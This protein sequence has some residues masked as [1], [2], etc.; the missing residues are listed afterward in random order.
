MI[1]TLAVMKT[2]TER[3]EDL[4]SRPAL[5]FTPKQ[6][7]MLSSAS[8]KSNQKKS[9]VT[10]S[11][12]LTIVCGE[13]S[14][15]HLQFTFPSPKSAKENGEKEEDENSIGSEGSREARQHP[16]E[17]T[18]ATSWWLFLCQK[19]ILPCLPS[20]QHSAEN[21]RHISE[22]LRE[23]DRAEEAVCEVD[24]Q[25]GQDEGA[26]L[27]HSLGKA[28]FHLFNQFWSPQL[29]KQTTIPSSHAGETGK[30][31]A[32]DANSFLSLLCGTRMFSLGG[33]DTVR[34][35]QLVENMR[36]EMNV[37]RGE[38]RAAVEGVDE[39]RGTAELF[40]EVRG[41][42][43]NESDVHN[44]INRKNDENNFSLNA[45]E[46]ELYAI[47][48]NILLDPLLFASSVFFK[49]QQL[50]L[51]ASENAIF[52]S[53]QRIACVP[54]IKK[55]LLEL[56]SLTFQVVPLCIEYPQKGEQHSILTFSLKLMVKKDLLHKISAIFETHHV[57]KPS[58]SPSMFISASLIQ[59]LEVVGAAFAHATP[60]A[61]ASVQQTSE[62]QST[63][64][65]SNITTDALD[66]SGSSN[67]AADEANTTSVGMR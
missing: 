53:P 20:E 2:T 36:K 7:K 46:R 57:Q 33:E 17:D 19:G 12:T 31:L 40:C 43:S 5:R 44:K 64:L 61:F 13:L 3:K 28:L 24:E 65:A 38:G 59:R 34:D 6:R 27:L 4:T 50:L 55:T 37:W 63:S 42:Y 15:T 21:C 45:M 8:Q 18:A 30:V 29:P 39:A 10:F 22:Q 62:S 25:I 67:P 35:A 54:S 16:P 66:L 47:N 23:T 1:V 49:N 11:H 48:A 14:P 58:S 51:S 9:H 60:S 26:Y 32:N 56:T 41:I 52:V